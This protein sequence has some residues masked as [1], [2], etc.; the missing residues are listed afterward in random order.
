M[1]IGKDII[2]VGS[3]AIAAIAA[4]LAITGGSMIAENPM[5]NV[6]FLPADSI[7]VVMPAPVDN[8]QMFQ[9]PI[10]P[11][12]P[13]DEFTGG[14]QIEAILIASDEDG[15]NRHEI[16]HSVYTVPVSGDSVES[17]TKVTQYTQFQFD[18]PANR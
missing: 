14:E 9:Q 7:S 12:K 5:K 8:E 1:P 16:A 15:N 13:S 4:T 18:V 10:I 6:A 3:G 11:N 17:I 2:K